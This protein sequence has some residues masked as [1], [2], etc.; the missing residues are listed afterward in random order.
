MIV[1]F[2]WA[3]VSPEW[4]VHAGKTLVAAGDGPSRAGLPSTGAPLV[5]YFRLSEH[6]KLAGQNLGRHLQT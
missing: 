4:L 6:L 1:P 5:A 3:W 2:T